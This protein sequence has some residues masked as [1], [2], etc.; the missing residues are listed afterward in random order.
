M[1]NTDI[2]NQAI[3]AICENISV[4]DKRR[5]ISDEERKLSLS[6]L[7]SEL[8]KLK[9]EENDP[10]SIYE[11]FASIV[12]DL[13][14]EEKLY[15]CKEILSHSS[16][17]NE[18]ERDEL[19][20]VEETTAG[21]HGKVAYVRNNYNDMAFERF[22]QRIPNA[23]AVVTSSFT[24]AC[25]EVFDNR[26]EFCILPL[27]NTGDGRLFGFYSMLDRYD[28]KIL[29]ALNI[30]TDD[31]QRSIRFGLVGKGVAKSALTTLLKKHSTCI[32]E[33]SVAAEDAS[34]TEGI[35]SAAN[36]ASA[37]LWQVD[38]LPVVYD[39]RMRRFFFNM[40]ISA[41]ELQAFCLYLSM[42][43]SSYSL[44]GFYPESINK[45]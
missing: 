7:T 21:S 43:F 2:Q 26:C 17:F 40:R 41:D 11:S 42:E 27:E 19:L 12:S 34:L 5:S 28:L 39:D 18:H 37:L 4:F 44:I 23:K 20:S 38:S 3:L 29:S 25:E 45:K 30:D 16:Y 22:S 1:S 15:F 32:L 6:M 36:A 24:D 10:R 35:L 14:G 8:L 33:F 9:A 13:R 31:R